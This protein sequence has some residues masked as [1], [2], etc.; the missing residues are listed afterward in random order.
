MSRIRRE[1][2]Q[3]M[4]GLTASGGELSAR[5]RFPESF[6]GFQ[7][8][9]PEKKILPGVC[10][11]QCAMSL[12][13]ERMKRQVVLREAVM[14]KFFHPIE[15]DQ[16]I[17]CTCTGMQEGTDSEFTLKAVMSRDGQKVSEMKL[18]VSYEE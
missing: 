17:A 11:L 9:F 15:P 2:V 5:F 6:I 7:G 3:C 8:H 4:S 12:V 18:R 13:E 10:Q 16:E 14:V 1:I